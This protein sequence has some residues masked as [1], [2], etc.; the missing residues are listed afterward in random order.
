MA[1]QFT[2]DEV[3]ALKAFAAGMLNAM[4]PAAAS[5]GASPSPAPSGGVAPASDLDSKYGDEKIKMN[6]RDW[7][8]TPRKGQTMSQA[9]PEF[10]D[11]YAE[12]MDYFAGKN[13][14][15]TKAGYDRRSASRARGW[16][17]RMRGGWKAP[18]PPPEPEN[19]FASNGGGGGFGN[20]TGGFGDSAHD[21]NEEIP[22]G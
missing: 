1:D 20:D 13:E 12:S 8:G 15:P 9:E 3:R 17:A 21:D 11:M 6:P 19:P 2:A 22:F 7:K 10:L 18:P 16:A 14:D 5:K 4:R